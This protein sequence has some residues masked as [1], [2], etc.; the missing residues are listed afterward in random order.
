[1]TGLWLPPSPNTKINHAFVSQI[2]LT[3]LLREREWPDGLAE[4]VADAV[5]CHHGNRASP[6]TLNNLE[7]D[8]RAIGRNDWT[9]ARKGILEA[10]LE[11]LKP[12]KNLLFLTA[13]E[14]C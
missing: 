5:G 12:G 9:Q 8:E 6:T 13:P 7:G 1:M 4:L 14:I 2:V 11:I 3:K 10:L